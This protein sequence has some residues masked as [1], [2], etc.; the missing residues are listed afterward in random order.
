MPKF[1]LTVEGKFDPRNP[2]TVNPPDLQLKSLEW[3]ENETPDIIIISDEIMLVKLG[4]YLSEGNHYS[5]RKASIAKL[6]N[7]QLQK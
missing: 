1:D 4:K 7:G 5:Y 6:V 3:N 2:L